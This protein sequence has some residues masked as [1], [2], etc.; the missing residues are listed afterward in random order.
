[1]FR[2][3]VKGRLRHLPKSRYVL[4]VSGHEAAASSQGGGRARRSCTRQMSQRL[5]LPRV[6]SDDETPGDSSAPQVD[7]V[8]E[9]LCLAARFHALPV[10]PD[11]LAHQFRASERLS[12]PEL[13]PAA[14]Q[15]GMSARSSR[16]AWRI[17]WRSRQGNG[18][19]LSI[20]CRH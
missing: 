11:Q 4:G 16:Q 17:R 2:V 14:R 9:T 8:L 13:I 15:L 10:G 12:A 18:G 5:S 20:S 1:M 7:T 6:S 19:L 3:R